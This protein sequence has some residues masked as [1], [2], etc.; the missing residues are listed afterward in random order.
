MSLGQHFK[1]SLRNGTGSSGTY[2]VKARFF[3]FASDGSITWDSSEQ[4]LFGS[5]SISAGAWADGAAFDNSTTKWTG[6]DLRIECSTSLAHLVTVQ[7]KVSTDGGSNY[8][9]DGYGVG[10][11][12][13]YAASAATPNAGLRM[14]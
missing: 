5:A 14:F 7:R 12:T 3:K 1:I 13:V 10:V 11:G 2:V 9:S 6:A 4:T 8:P